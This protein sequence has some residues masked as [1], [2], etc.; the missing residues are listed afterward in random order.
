MRHNLKNKPLFLMGRM[1]TEVLLKGTGKLD[2]SRIKLDRIR[3]MEVPSFVSHEP[4][5]RAIEKGV[6]RFRGLKN[7]VVM[8]N[9]GSINNIKA[10]HGALNKGGKNVFFLSTMEPGEIGRIKLMCNRDETLVMPVTKSG[11]N[12]CPLEGLLSFL[13]YPMLPVT[14]GDRGVLLEIS[15]RRKLDYIEHPDVG[16]RFSG[17]TSCAFAPASFMGIDI[18]KVNKGALEM[19]QRCAPNVR[20]EKNPALMVSSALYLLEKK[21]YTEVF[22]QTYSTRLVSFLPLI[23]QIMHESVCKKGAGQTFY[24]GLGPET[25][26]HTNQRFLGGRKN[27]VGLF[28]RV[29]GF[30]ND[31]EISVPKDLMDI[32]LRSGKLGDISGSCS[33]HLGF[34]L[35]GVLDSTRKAGI[36]HIIISVK[37]VTPESAGEYLALWQ[38]VGVYSAL[39][40]G[41]NPYDQPDVENAKEVSFRLRKGS[42]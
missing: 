9:G 18:K 25:Q 2:F 33:E 24:G 10:L 16:G 6:A 42:G 26:H 4:D 35:E 8:G 30:D 31:V 11:T 3:S 15:R 32:P 19:Y 23:T 40:R 17:R 20:I 22:C 5:F 13:D 28:T 1:E 7:I 36:P 34:E 29:R 21:G 27:A 14:S 41:V 12:V 39:L 38:Y 37:R